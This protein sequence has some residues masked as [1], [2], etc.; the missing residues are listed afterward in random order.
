MKF[1]LERRKFLKIL[2]HPFT[3]LSAFAT[4]IGIKFA[5]S[6]RSGEEVIKYNWKA[7]PLKINEVKDLGKVFL[8]RD[9]DGIYAMLAKCT[10]LGC[11]P[12]W[13]G[14]IFH[15]PCHGSEF[16]EEGDVIMGPARKHLINLLVKKKGNMLYIYLN[17]PAPYS[18]RVKV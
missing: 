11:K 1:D 12:M 10:H 15:C 7:S 6:G 5:L 4:Y 2:F 14:K 13:N 16:T 8:V 17:K 9:K 3:W 18:Q